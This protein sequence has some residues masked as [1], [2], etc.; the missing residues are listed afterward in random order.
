MKETGENRQELCM[1]YFTNLLEAGVFDV[2]N[3]S[4]TLDFNADGELM[5]IRINILAYKKTKDLL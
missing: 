2:K 5:Q 3:G 4:A 1:R